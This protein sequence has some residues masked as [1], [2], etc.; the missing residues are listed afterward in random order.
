MNFANHKLNNFN[1][2]LS[3][4]FINK[5]NSKLEKEL[6]FIQKDYNFI[7]LEKSLTKQTLLSRA[8]A[9]RFFD[10]SLK[11]FL[12]KKINLFLCKKLNKKNQKFIINPMIY[13]RFCRPGEKLIKNYQK[14]KFYTEPHYDKSFDNTKFYSIWI[15][16]DDTSYDT[17]SLCYFDIPQELRKKKFPVKGKNKYS[18]H[19]YF[20]KPENA[21]Q[22]L[23]QYCKPVYL[24][25]GDIIFFNK[26]CLH[27]ATKP[28]K[29]VRLSINF[30]MFD[31]KILKSKN[32]N[33]KNKFILSDYSLDI[34][35][36]INL[37]LINDI[38]GAKRVYKKINKKKI[39]KSINLFN[40]E[41][42]KNIKKLIL[43][44]SKM[45]S[46]NFIKNYEKDLHYSKELSILKI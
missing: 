9:Y 41:V 17:G 37:L 35:N 25:K 23:E 3:K 33:E 24:T 6:K 15:P 8:L 40:P 14:A 12:E 10:D 30:Q 19:N 2:F 43:G 26:Y 34:C 31:S 4:K 18:M 16:L 36:F 39:N 42:N 28:I 32:N 38:L 27:G 13:V 7:N 20:K 45:K 44:F 1:K 11:I 22:L 5:L 46:V 21:D 29:R